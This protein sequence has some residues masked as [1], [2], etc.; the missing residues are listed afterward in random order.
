VAHEL[1]IL[2]RKS[3]TIAFTRRVA[4]LKCDL[5]MDVRQ[6]GEIS[7]SI[8]GEHDATLWTEP[9]PTSRTVSPGLTWR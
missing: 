8:C 1:E 7:S 3:A 6:A 5:L 2:Q 4:E 9:Q